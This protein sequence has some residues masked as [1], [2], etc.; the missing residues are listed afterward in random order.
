ML[1]RSLFKALPIPTKLHHT[2][3]KRLI[4]HEYQVADLLAKEKLPI[5]EVK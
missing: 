5:V 4:L 3:I 2:P 1:K